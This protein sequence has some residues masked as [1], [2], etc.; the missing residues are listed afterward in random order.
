M[1]DFRLKDQE[2]PFVSIVLPVFNEERYLELCLKTLRQMTYPR[3]KYEII[4]VDNGSVDNSFNIAEKHADQALCLPGVNVGAVRN[5][6]VKH[7]RGEVLA[8]LDSDCLVLEN[9]LNQGV[10]L[11]CS[12]RNSV[13]GGNLNLRDD[14]YWIEKFW[15]LDNNKDKVPQ[16]DL[17]GSCIFI[18]RETFLDAGGFDE[19]V[20]SGEDSA[21]SSTL[22]DLGYKV[23]I[24]GSLGV[25]HLGNPTT[26]RGFIRR[27][28]WHSEN[29]VKAFRDSLKDKMFWLLI[30]YMIGVSGLLMSVFVTFPGAM[31][32]I[33][34]IICP[35]L[36]LSAKRIVRAKFKPK[37]ITDIVSIYIIDNLYLIG[38]ALGM[39]KGIVKLKTATR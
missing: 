18:R 20:T 37:S 13:Y 30:I 23:K 33:A 6:G 16:H 14:P 36:I 32:F 24:D 27:Q 38:R 35:P 15:L 31:F 3:D 8:F 1:T 34:A 22:V 28:I 11:L 4:T 29:Y 9:W 17:L 19:R 21:L 25:V 12:E 39:L 5:F 2:L 7:A 26:V 10:G